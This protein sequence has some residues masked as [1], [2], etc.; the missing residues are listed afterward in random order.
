ML[1]VKNNW[2]DQL[3]S[4]CSWNIPSAIQQGCV[5]FIALIESP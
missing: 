5:N 2:V 4:Q 1:A 3:T